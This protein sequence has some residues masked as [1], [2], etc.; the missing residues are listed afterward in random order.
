VHY[1]GDGVKVSSTVS[2]KNGGLLRSSKAVVEED[3]EKLSLKN[4]D[5][6]LQ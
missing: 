2:T 6:A 5:Q 4:P 3:L 1:T